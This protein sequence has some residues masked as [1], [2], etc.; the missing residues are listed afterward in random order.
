MSNQNT[1]PDWGEN[2]NYKYC[3]RC[4]NQ[5]LAK[6]VICVKCSYTFPEFQT[7]T[8]NNPWSGLAM[9]LLIIGTLFIPLFGEVMGFISMQN[10]ARRSQGILLLTLGII[11]DVIFLLIIIFGFVSFFHTDIYYNRPFYY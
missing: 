6:A 3:P 9:F 11:R 10:S 5:A 7:S 2:R 4:G 1:D 8:Q